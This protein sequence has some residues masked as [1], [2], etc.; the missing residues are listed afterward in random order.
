[1]GQEQVVTT[2]HE[3]L[4]LL[5]RIGESRIERQFDQ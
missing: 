3:G 2:L 1:V 4:Q 5:D